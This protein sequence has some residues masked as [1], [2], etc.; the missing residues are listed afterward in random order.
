MKILDLVLHPVRLRILHAMYGGQSHTT[1]DLCAH[2]ADVPKTSVYRHVSLLTEAGMLEVVDE[3]RVHGAVERHYRLRRDRTTIGPE[4]ARSMSTEDH[5]QGFAA[6]LAA[7]LAEFNA[8]LDRDDAVPVEDYVGYQQLPLWLSREELH[9]LVDK[10]VELIEPL[11]RNEPTPE[12]GLHMLS[13]IV[14]PLQ[15]PPGQ[16]SEDD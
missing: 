6:A 4:A 3:K 13:P 1:S 8:Y 12:R 2:L 11:S 5:R 16:A 14:F 9:D 7:L 15:R 10:F